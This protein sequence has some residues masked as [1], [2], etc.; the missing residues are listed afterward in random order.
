MT[1]DCNDQYSVLTICGK[2]RSVVIHIQNIYNEV[3]GDHLSQTIVVPSGHCHVVAVF[4]L[5]VNTVTRSRSD[6]VS[7]KYDSRRR[8]NTEP[9]IHSLTFSMIKDRISLNVMTPEILL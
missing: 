2:C 4:L 1:K 9:E 3:D 8:V 7:H 6:T 5:V